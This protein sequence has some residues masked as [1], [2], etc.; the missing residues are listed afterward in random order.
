MKKIEG[1]KPRHWMKIQRAFLDVSQEGLAELLGVSKSLIKAYERESRNIPDR[2]INQIA[3]LVKK[4]KM[5]G[6]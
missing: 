3:E 1:L 6:R 4:E 5:N 2:R